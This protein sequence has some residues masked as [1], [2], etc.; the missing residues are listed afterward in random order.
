MA[1]PLTLAL[2]LL[3]RLPPSKVNENLETLISLCPSLAEELISSVDQPSVMRQDKN[4]HGREYLCCD[5]NR[6][7]DSYRSPWSSTYDPPLEDGTQPPARLRELEVR[8]N[9]AFNT[10]RQLYYDGGLS[11]VYLW[12]LDA[13]GFAGVVLFKKELDDDR[14]PG[15]WDSLHVFEVSEKSRTATYELTSTIMLSLGRTDKQ[16]SLQLAGS[17]TRQ[18]RAD[19]AL[20]DQA[21]H[22]SNMG[23]MIEDMETKMRNQLQ[24]VY[25]GKTKDIV[26]T[27]RSVDSLSK[28][29]HA[30][31]LQKELMGLWK[32]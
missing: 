1:D 13:A 7:G 24:E 18:S 16:T 10:Y 25:F 12:E 21:S 22:V 17:L 8:A 2:D 32:K 4:A 23:K 29:R 19:Q 20:K 15:C 3:R 31:D 6:D 27:L 14:T 9:E 11:S 26:G 30:Q 28:L 5:Y